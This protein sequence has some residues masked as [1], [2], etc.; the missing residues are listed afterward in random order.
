MNSDPL[1]ILLRHNHWA[2][3]VLLDACAKLSREQFHQQFEIGCG[4]LHDTLAHI[5]GCVERWIERVRGKLSERGPKRDWSIDELRARLEEST[6]NLSDLINELQLADLMDSTRT[7]TFPSNQG[8]TVEFTFTAGAAIVH[9]LVHGSHH[10][11]QALNMLR[12]LGVSPLPELDVIDWVFY[13]DSK[14]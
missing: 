13:V 7:Q 9:C 10:R 12:R 14:R 5:I 11:A 6:A 4:N 1:T 8:G 3:G 2:T